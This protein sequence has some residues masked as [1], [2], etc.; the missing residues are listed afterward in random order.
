MPNASRHRHVPV[1]RRVPVDRDDRSDRKGGANDRR[2]VRKGVPD[3]SPNA[4]SG[5]RSIGSHHISARFTNWL[6]VS[7]R[8]QFCG[9]MPYALDA[10]EDD[11][12]ASAGIAGKRVSTS[13]QKRDGLSSDI[14]D[15]SLVDSCGIYASYSRE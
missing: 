13:I 10:V 15:P 9:T 7:A 3:R 5:V 12:L 2:G 8:H 1:D 4:R 11:E 6:A 14:S